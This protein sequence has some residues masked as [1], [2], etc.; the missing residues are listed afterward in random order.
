M[1]MYRLGEVIFCVIYQ[2][3]AFKDTSGRKVG[4]K[5]ISLRSKL[6]EGKEKEK[7]VNGQFTK[8]K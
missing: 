8:G 7:V 2:R 6:T 3:I 4:N 5:I 1:P